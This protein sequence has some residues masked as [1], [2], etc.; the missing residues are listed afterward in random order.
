MVVRS[1]RRTPPRSSPNVQ[2]KYVLQRALSRWPQ[3]LIHSAWRL[4]MQTRALLDNVLMV[5][6][7]AVVLVRSLALDSNCA[8]P[9]SAAK[10]A[11]LVG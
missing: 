11:D 2:R 1:C 8:Q 7:L 6:C 10:A 5:C 3:L 4:G 9:A